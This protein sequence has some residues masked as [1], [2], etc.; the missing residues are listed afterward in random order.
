MFTLNEKIQEIIF[1]IFLFSSHSNPLDNSITQLTT[2]RLWLSIPSNSYVCGKHDNDEEGNIF[3]LWIEAL[4]IELNN[5]DALSSDDDD[6]ETAK[7][8]FS[9]KKMSFLM[10][11]L[12]KIFT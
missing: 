11:Y 6:D 9:I 4:N 7:R 8:E 10:K 3:M 2:V 12:V 5:H 1:N